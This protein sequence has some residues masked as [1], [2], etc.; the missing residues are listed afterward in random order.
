M[1][2]NILGTFILGFISII[3]GVVL[4]SSIGNSTESFDDIDRVNTTIAISNA[5]FQLPQT[6]VTGILFFGSVQNNTEDS[7]V[8]IGQNVN[9]TRAG[10]ITVGKNIS[11][12]ETNTFFTDKTYNITY[13][14][15]GDNFVGDGTSRVLTNLVVLFFAL[16]I[17][18]GA[19]A[20]VRQIY[21]DMF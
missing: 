14:H 18:L 4:I 21:P 20:M 6:D 5:R 11:N 2:K 10:L 9:F 12:N 3:V 13:T 19:F 8:V 16:A 1:E 17:A 7:V 15:E